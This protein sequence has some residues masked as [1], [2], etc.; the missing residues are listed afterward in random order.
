MIEQ[1][2]HLLRI[3]ELPHVNLHVV[4]ADVGMHAGLAGAFIL[5]RT[6]DGGEVAHLDTP[7]R[8]HVTDRPDDV[9]SLQRRWENLRGEAL[10]RR[11]S[12][13]LIKELAKSWI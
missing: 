5:A 6:P 4:P 13:D 12:R 9:D 2:E 10:P 11:A 3:T 8:A 1:F 7:L